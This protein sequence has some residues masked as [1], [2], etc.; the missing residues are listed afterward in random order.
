MA[1]KKDLAEQL[2]EDYDVEVE[3]IE[4]YKHA[5]LKTL[6][7]KHKKLEKLQ[8]QV[9][10]DS[11]VDI[12]IEDIDVKTLE[13]KIEEVKENQTKQITE[14]AKVKVVEPTFVKGEHFDKGETIKVDPDFAKRV[15]E[16]NDNQLEVVYLPN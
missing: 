1:T 13:E 9:G 11:N 5:Q 7:K 16:E 14:Q 6:L 15:L 10:E 4:D 8:T 12:D 3:D 2:E